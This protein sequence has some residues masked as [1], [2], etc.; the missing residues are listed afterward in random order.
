MVSMYKAKPSFQHSRKVATKIGAAFTMNIK[1][2]TGDIETTPKIY[3]KMA[4][5]ITRGSTPKPYTFPSQL[6]GIP[7]SCP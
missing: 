5:A 6:L 7:D 3:K 2:I 1:N 4:M